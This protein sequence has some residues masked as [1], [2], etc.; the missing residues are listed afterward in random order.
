[1]IDLLDAYGALVWQPIEAHPEDARFYVVPDVEVAATIDL[2]TGWLWQ[3]DSEHGPAPRDPLTIAVREALLSLLVV[4]GDRDP[5]AFQLACPPEAAQPV[6]SRQVVEGGRSLAAAAALIL[7]GGLQY[8]DLR[9]ATGPDL[10]GV[11][12]LALR[13]D[14][15]G[16]E[17][18]Q[19]FVRGV[20]HLRG[21]SLAQTL[22]ERVAATANESVA[23]GFAALAV[24]Y[25]QSP[26]CSRPDRRLIRQALLAGARER[27][28]THAV[29]V[30][31]MGTE[32]DPI[33]AVR[34]ADRRTAFRGLLR[35]SSRAGLPTQPP[36]HA[37]VDEASSD[38]EGPGPGAG[39]G[40]DR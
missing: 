12:E 32:R 33:A 4:L 39:S 7:L 29:H 6:L 3:V 8:V 38:A 31:G 10:I 24:G 30:V 5:V 34:G 26:A 13:M 18:A 36:E 14:P 11:L 23:Q 1:V 19:T 15:L 2:L 40:S 37:S 28:G 17:A 27:R 25:L 35:R 21:D 22:L 16:R 20:R 9:P